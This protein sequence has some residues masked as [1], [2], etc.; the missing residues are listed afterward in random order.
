MTLNPPNKK[1]PAH[2]QAAR[3]HLRR[4]GWSNREAAA[5]FGVGET[6]LSR[7]LNNRRESARLIHRI[8]TLTENPRPA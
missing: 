3:T 6:H 5:L 8:M 7:V 2:I 4:N 1:L